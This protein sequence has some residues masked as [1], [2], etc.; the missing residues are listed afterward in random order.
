RV[1]ARGRVRER[2][3]QHAPA[4][5]PRRR[6]VRRRPETGRRD[7]AGAG[8]AAACRARVA[9]G[10]RP[11]L[12][13]CAGLGAHGG[14][15]MNPVIRVGLVEDDRGIRDTLAALIGGAPGFEC[16]GVF[17]A[18]EPAIESLPR[19]VPDVLLMDINL[20]GM[21]GIDGVRHLR[22]ILPAMQVIMLTVYEDEDLIFRSLM[23]GASGYLLKRTPAE[24]LLEAIADAR[25]GCSPM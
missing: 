14:T 1:A 20:P 9:T 18:V 24:K 16:V 19:K 8:P 15:P 7:H 25:R 23:A 10:A 5:R 21:S 4:E 22:E 3:R 11:V 12:A 17:S 6:R 2:A 13:A